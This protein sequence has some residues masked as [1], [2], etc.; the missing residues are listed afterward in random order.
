M[1]LLIVDGVLN[2]T[3]RRAAHSHT[4]LRICWSREG[5]EGNL[6]VS[7]QA[8]YGPWSIR[9]CGAPPAEDA[10]VDIME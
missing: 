7:Q 5:T 1:A 10:A 9:T 2:L 6:G 4:Q 8:G 3:D